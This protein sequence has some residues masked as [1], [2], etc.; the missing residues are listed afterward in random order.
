MHLTVLRSRDCDSL[1]GVVPSARKATLRKL[2]AGG[3]LSLCFWRTVG[4]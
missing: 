1:S 2:A 3:N 4:L